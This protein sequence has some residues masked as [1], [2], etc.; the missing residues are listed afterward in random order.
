MKKLIVIF[1]VICISAASTYAQMSQI[2][3][4]KSRK[5]IANYEEGLYNYKLFAYD[6]ALQN[7]NDAIKIDPTFTEAYYL[8]AGVYSHKKDDDKMIETLQLAVQNCGS[9]DPMPY[10]K[11]AVELLSM[12]RY[13]EALQNFK[14]IQPKDKALFSPREQEQIAYGTRQSADAIRIMKQPIP[15]SPTNMGTNINTQFDDYHPAIT[16]DDNLF[17]FT[18]NI[19]INAR[20]TQ[21]D[22][23]YSTKKDNE[24]QVRHRFPAPI[25]TQNNEGAASI[26]ADGR[27]M[28]YTMC[29]APSGYGSCDIYITYYALGQWTMPKNI[30]APINTKAWESQPSLSADGKTLYF[31]SNRDGGKGKKDIWVS[32]NVS[33]GKW[34]EPE[35]LGATI[36]TIYDEEAP[37]IHADGKTLFFSSNGHLG[38]GKKDI[39]ITQLNADGTWKTP[40]NAG[41]PLNSKDDEGLVI[42]NAQGS[43]GYFASN[44][45]GG[46][47]GLDVYEFSINADM[48]AIMPYPVTYVQGVVFNAKDKQ[49]RIAAQLDLRDVET[50][51]LL[52]TS[53]ADYNGNFT[54]PFME[55][56][57]YALSVS[58]PGYLFY[59]AQVNLESNR[60]LIEVPLQPIE[61]GS[62]VVL[63][64]VFFDTDSYELKPESQA[65]LLTIVDYMNLNPTLSFEIGGHTDNTGIKQNNVTLSNNR[66]Q[67]VYTF[68]TEHG[69]AA[70]RLTF[71]G[72]ADTKA[73]VP[74]DSEENKAKN[75]RTELKITKK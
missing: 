7:L 50:N 52:F 16:V 36:N 60:T 73:L 18:S 66:A 59:S 57:N 35:N 55:N 45:E 28:V 8:L 11:L 70:T 1:G 4:S 19:P 67:A 41:Y 47:G 62:S 13:A 75:R 3:S 6:K 21:E 34:S 40:V 68:L 69:I 14:K 43:K 5:A 31:V 26:S 37:F 64:N 51:E 56:K 48:F 39:M 9:G 29:N 53:N 33:E 25:T 2:Y 71:K 61:I 12:G 10:Y 42:I 32:R 38:L 72:Y 65:E 23:F 58:S 74:N 27:T 54:V 44:R 24:W 17:I 30:G 22:I 15:F 46:L 20:M 49:K 63:N